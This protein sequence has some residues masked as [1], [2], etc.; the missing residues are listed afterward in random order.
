MRIH[1]GWLNRRVTV[2]TPA[3]G[4]DANGEPLTGW[5]DVATVWASITDVSGREYVAAGGLQN[6]AKTKILIRYR[7]GVVPAMR[8]VNGTDIYN[9][10]A[11]LGQDRE[12]LMLMCTRAA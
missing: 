10:E 5:T 2:Q 4:Q 6:A 8:V 12:S 3:T 7:A 11:V 1:S 9:I